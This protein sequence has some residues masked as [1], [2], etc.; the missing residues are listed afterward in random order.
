VHAARGEELTNERVREL[1]GV[2]SKD[3]RRTLK[4][5]TEAGFLEQFGERGG[6]HYVLSSSVDAPVAFRLSPTALRELV[7]SLAT[8]GA[9][10]NTIV[11][12]AH[13]ARP[14]RGSSIASGAGSRWSADPTRRA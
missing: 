3:A 11:R 14:W 1:L 10:T 2:D 8:A 9:I 12:N 13:R 6:A 5:L 4:R 7:V